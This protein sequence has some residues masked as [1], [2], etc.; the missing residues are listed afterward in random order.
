[1]K[2][3]VKIFLHYLLGILGIILISCV[4][5][6]FSKVTSW[7][8]STYWEALKSIFTAIFHPTKWEISYQGSAEVF[9]VSLADFITG[10]Y[11]YS[12]KIIV[13]SLVISAL[14]AYLLV[15]A[16]FRG[17]KWLRRGLSGFLS[18]LQA[19]PDFSFI[20]LIQM[21]VVY[22]YQQTGVFTLNFYSLN[23]EQIYA[24][25]IVCLSIIPT[26]LFYKMMM[27]LMENEWQAD[28]IQLA[29]G[30]GLNDRAI[31]LRHATP[32]M[33]Q[34][35]FY[36]SK[37]IVWFILSAYLVVEFLFGIEGVLYYL[38]AGFSPLN[39]FLV[40]ALVFTPFY[41]FYTLIDLWI[42]RGKNTE[43]ANVTRIPLH[44]NSFQ[45]PLRKK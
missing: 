38:L 15:I 11:F 19:F 24:A 8:S 42:S 22:I 26:V 23:G 10:P 33:M 12:M 29:R 40:L 2:R 20:F 18:I 45:K 21:A 9:H 31:L 32:N 6:I 28:Y 17:P 39:I 3:I 27:L 35:L 43:S 16:T 25:P 36:Q 41:F 30:K 7:S 14:I 4:P 13:A 34:S 37:T 1:M 5:A 44:W